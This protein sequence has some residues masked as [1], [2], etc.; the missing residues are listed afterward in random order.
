MSPAEL[1]PWLLLVG[2]DGYV[3]SRR[4]RAILAYIGRTP[5]D[6]AGTL[7]LEE[8]KVR[9]YLRAHRPRRLDALATAKWAAALQDLGWVPGSI[10]L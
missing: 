6:L 10:R 3:E 8:E 5:A 9:S 1:R 4:L 2:G 7:G